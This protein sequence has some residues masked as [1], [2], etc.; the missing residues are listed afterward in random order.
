VISQGLN[1]RN[2]TGDEIVRR[3]HLHELDVL[4]SQLEALNLRDVP[5]MPEQLSNRLRAAGIGHRSDASV[6]DVLDLVFRAQE[7]YLRPG[8]GTRRYS[9]A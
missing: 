1:I 3:I 8:Y 2:L 6:T 4:L 9:A 5:L 7:V